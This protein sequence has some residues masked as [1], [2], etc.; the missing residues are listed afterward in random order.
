VS[1]ISF[2]IIT[3][4]YNRAA[5]GLIEEAVKSLQA[6]KKGPF[7]YEHIIIDDGS[8]DST[9]QL[10]R[11]LAAK[12]S[13][14]KYIKQENSGTPRAIRR[15]IAEASGDWLC[16][17]GDDDVLPNNSLL[18]RTEFINK[19]SKVDWFY[20]KTQWVDENLKPIKTWTQSIPVPSNPYERMLAENF[21]QGGTVTIKK[22]LYE[23]I[24]WPKW[25]KKSDD[26]YV[27]LELLR[28]ENNYTLGFL[29]EKLY[30]Y[31][32]HNIGIGMQSGRSLK[33][34]KSAQQRWELDDKI[35]KL[36]NP[37]LAYLA[38]ELNRAWRENRELRHEVERLSV[39]EK[40]YHEKDKYIKNL[41]QS[42]SWKILQKL[43][44]LK[45]RKNK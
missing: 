8:T 13:R 26:Y 30:C 15:G 9:E 36:H 19:N 11:E 3:P 39:Y 44:A 31:R 27:A 17:L 2:S 14:I 5:T 42:K 43:N 38:S 21:I 18:L 29:N 7:E 23:S 4:T 37:G 20:G 34:K 1:I 28:P 35:R 45:G 40:G 33:D 24:D 6:Q 32:R 22:S 25:L 41:Q 16:V 10:V 12:D